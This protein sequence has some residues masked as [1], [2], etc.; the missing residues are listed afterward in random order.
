MRT[1]KQSSDDEHDRRAESPATSRASPDLHTGAGLP[2]WD[3]R[4]DLLPVIRAAEVA[5][6]L[7]RCR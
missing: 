5:L 7:R 1:V 4:L 2:L 3:S 6:V